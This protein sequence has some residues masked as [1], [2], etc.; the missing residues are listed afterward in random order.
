ML[1]NGAGITA[2]LSST[3]H[4]TFPKTKIQAAFVSIMA[5]A[6][7]NWMKTCVELG[8]GRICQIF[9]R[10]TCGQS[11]GGSRVGG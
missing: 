3:V 8:C 10:I 4:G 7:V 6:G 1:V 9:V 5:V 2:I 11:C